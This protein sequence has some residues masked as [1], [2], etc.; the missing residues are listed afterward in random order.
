MRILYQVIGKDD[1]SHIIFMSDRQKGL[2]PTLEQQ[3]PR[4][5]ARDCGR[6][7]YANFKQ[8][9]SGLGFKKLF[10]Q[11]SKAAN[12]IHF[13]LAME[14]IKK[15]KTVGIAAHAW[16]SEIPP[17]K[18]SRSAFDTTSKIVHTTNNR[19]ECFNAWIDTYRDKP[20][21]NLMEYMSR[22]IMNRFIS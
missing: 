17:S 6:H 18:W 21:L 13:R 2:L 11:A 14:K 15:V 8:Q 10:W 1:G 7:I 22:K 16:L 9:W 5:T 19:T 20:V 12:E 4:A 3:W